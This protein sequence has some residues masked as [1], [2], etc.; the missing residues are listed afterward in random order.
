LS[1]LSP[2][3]ENLTVRRQRAVRKL[4][5]LGALTVGLFALAGP[6]S[7]LPPGFQETTV[8]SG[9]NQ[10]TVVRFASDGRVFVAEKSGLIKIFDSLSDPTPSTFADLRT[11]VHNFWDRGLL[12]MALDPQFPADPHVYVLYTHDA[13]IGGT[14]PRWGSPGTTDDGCPTPPG[15]TAD[16]CVVSGRLSRLTAS[17]N[18]MTGPEQVLIEDWCQQYP[19]HSIGTIEFGA[20]GALYVSGGDGASFNFADHG[21]D[22]N[23][24]NP[25][26]DPPGGVGAT[27]TRPTAEGGA[28]RSQD[29]RTSGDP[30]SLDGA[31][32]RVNPDTG[33]AMP[34]NPLFSNSD[35]N[36]RRIIAHGHRNPFRFTIRPGTN[37]V[38]IGDVGWTEWE[39]IDRIPSPAAPV[40]NFGWPCYEGPER[41]EG[42]DNPNLN[43][44]ENLYNPGNTNVVSPAYT[45]N[46]SEKVFT[47]EACP[48]GSSAI[49]GLAFYEGGNYPA[50]YDNA[51]FFTDY[52]R[53]CIWV[54]F[55]GS[56]GLPDPA[57]RQTFHVQDVGAVNLEIGPGGDLFF[58]DFDSS[59][60]RRI[61][62]TAS[63]NTPPT[64]A[65]Q[66]N[67][68][69]GPAPLTVNFDGTG[70]TDPDPGDTLTY[71]WDLD[72]DGQL[73][74]S[75]AAQP[76][77]T[78]TQTGNV[79]VTLRVTD[80]D[81]EWDEA[82]VTISPGNTPPSATITSPSATFT[83]KVGDVVNFSGS[84]SDG[85]Q[86]TLPASAL[87]WSLIMHH[88]FSET[89][90]HT[91]PLT[92]FP[93]VASGS[94]V[95]PDHEYPSHLEL[96]LTATDA[97]GLTDVES[98]RL[99]PKTVQLTFQTNPAGLN[100]VVGAA[101]QATP[102]TRTV[103]VGSSNSL[104]APSPQ[105]LGSNSYSFS[106]WSD[107]GAESHN[108]TAPETA[109][110]YTATFVDSPPLPS[111]LVAAYSMSAGSGT[112]LAD[113][114]GKGHT[115]TIAGATWS[116]AGKYGGALSFDGTDD[117]VTIA[118]ANDLD[119][120]NGMTL[121]AWV[122]PTELAGGWRT[123]AFKEGSPLAYTLY[124]DDGAG[125]PISEISTG[126]VFRN[127]RGTA[128]LALNTWSH[129]AGTYDGAALKLYVNGTLV[130]TLAV[131][132][133]MPVTTGVLRLGGNNL[134]DE[135]YQGL[136]DEVRVY[137]RALSQ[138][139]IQAAMATPADGPVTPPGAPTNLTANGS[140][141]SVSLAW[142]APSGGPAAAGYNV[143]R[144]TT[145]GF[146]PSLGNRIAEPTGTSYTDSGL[147]PGTYYY[148]VTAEDAAGNVGQPSNEANATVTGDISPP[149]VP[150][151]LTAN[152]G[153]SSVTLGWTASNDNVAVAH[154]NVHRGTTA[155][156]TPSL[157]NRI[158]TP[159]G[160]SYTDS[161]LQQG[162]YY[163]K[164]T[165]QDAAQN[166]SNPS[167]E[168]NAVVTGDV[169]APTVNLT[170][171][172]AG[173][174]VSGTINVTASASDNVG[175]AGVQ[176]KL[177]GQ[178]LGAEDTSAPY[179]VSW[180]TTTA[181]GGPHALTAVARD[182]AGNL[183][184]APNV[185]VAVDNTTP[186]PPAGL[187]AAYSM[188]AGSGTTVADATGKG[189]TGTI[190]GATWSAA[191]KNGGALSFDG[192]NDWVTIA[193]ANDL[194]LTT[195]MTL[196][197]WVRPTLLA[198]QWRTLI[199]KEGSPLA[200]TLYA[201]DRVSAPATEIVTG[202]TFRTA[203]GTG[204]LPLNAWSH[205]AATYD[206]ATLKLFV[207]A[208]QVRSVAVTGPMPVTTGVLRLGGNNLW[209]EWYA[210]LL[211]DVRVYNRALTQLEIQQ[212]LNTAVAP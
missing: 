79:L 190:S 200:Y 161:G 38:W 20:D 166:V 117:W 191:G 120:T 100:L 183:G 21:Q 197:A 30:V 103:I 139:E 115:G 55:A 28:L 133:D 16:G 54:M 66:A 149:S 92:N 132:G 129:L 147:Q 102:F 203:R 108:I 179:S 134:W 196:E 121:A 58:P 48:S 163:Y 94:F 78:Y 109:T 2:A 114:T 13:A 140:L 177:D 101:G 126:G 25:C 174:T 52:S 39:E 156:F 71:A 96:R 77:R 86:G 175:V 44:C 204:T 40:E 123:V 136:L 209:S 81:G 151:N 106:S 76:T 32:L 211:D 42:Y 135:W 70:S 29:L 69:S 107:G 18:V 188:N 210:G 49:S 150:G 67:P 34:D 152:G 113:V 3:W 167:N 137:N 146:T 72:G 83:W 143:H 164:V 73:D 85:Q 97:G 51:L 4:L 157:G 65:L 125:L 128:T 212:D 88:C 170:A 111:G 50:A 168:A 144:G 148:K 22:G 199:F 118:D 104:G 186:P 169:T 82:Q 185:N 37:E 35:P 138:A 160:T 74:D 173:S 57:T 208:T 130:R 110:T 61:R 112:T 162:T 181:A 205:L 10:P 154:Y 26:G 59:T 141:S 116:A 11:N 89:N 27:L 178:N 145:A 172:A 195:G 87:S 14:A 131:T 17:G 105:T 33:A 8:W 207:N 12:G 80:P 99:D 153:I 45:Y 31:I 19:S 158:A 9:L 46:H 193:D 142:T 68:T 15:P 155:G 1:G 122:N 63:T 180:N 124:A 5:W 6:A 47:G 119:L 91:H 90:C 60:I 23:P 202:G 206:G 7:A 95:A 182:A 93:G 56:N 127:A 53:E 187:V 184:N 192:V 36:A 75:T 64:A 84:A 194:D 165:A 43:I 171:P 201:H 62:F 176:F 24:L 41:Q 98:L 159:T 198:G 189:H